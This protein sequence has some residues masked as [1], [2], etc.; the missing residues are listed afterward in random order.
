[1]WRARDANCEGHS[2]ACAGCWCDYSR[3]FIIG[4]FG[5]CFKMMECLMHAHWWRKRSRAD[6]VCWDHPGRTI[7]IPL[8]GD[9]QQCQRCKTRWINART[10]SALSYAHTATYNS[11]M[12]IFGGAVYPGGGQLNTGPETG[13]IPPSVSHFFLRLLLSHLSPSMSFY[14]HSRLFS[15]N[16][17]PGWG[18]GAA[19]LLRAEHRSLCRADYST[20]RKGWFTSGGFGV[21]VIGL[22]SLDIA[23]DW[24]R[25]IEP[26]NCVG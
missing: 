6:R 19:L 24:E 12:S 23:Y 5:E 14:L 21:V 13:S 9:R 8:S 15:S 3:R 10:F 2:N 20:H 11:F 4:S 7:V 18:R 17:L 25:L 26:S 16:S 22:Y 1:M